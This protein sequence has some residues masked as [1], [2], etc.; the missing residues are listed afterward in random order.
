MAA[1]FQLSLVDTPTTARAD[2]HTT[3]LPLE[4]QLDDRTIREARETAARA[5]DTLRALGGC[6]VRQPFTLQNGAAQ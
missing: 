2:A 6:V 3:V 1:S 4:T 5:A